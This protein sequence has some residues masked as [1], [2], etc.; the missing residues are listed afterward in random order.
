MKKLI[1]VFF[2]FISASAIAQP[3]TNSW[4]DYN[5]T[6]YKFSVGKTGLY[7]ISQPALNAVGLGNTPAEQFQLW[8]N[9]EEVGLYTTVTT[10]PL[11]SSDYLEFWGLMND[12]KKDA[13]LYRDPDYQLSDYYSLETDT[14]AYFLTVNPAGNN[15]RFV[16][17]PNNVTGNV[18]PPEPYFIN[19]RSVYFNNKINPGLGIPL[20][21][22]VYSSSYDIGEG[23]TSNDVAPSF[24]LSYLI[25]SIYMFTA[26]PLASVNFAV[27]GNA[28]NTRNVRVK[29]YNNVIDDESMSFFTY[30]K[31]RVDNIPASY[32]P[33]P[34]HVIISIEPVSSTSTDRIVVSTFSLTY[35]SKFNF[36]NKKS[37]YFELPAT[38]TGNYLLIDNFNFGNTKPVLLDITSGARYIADITSIPGKLQFVL[39][40]SS[41]TL[42]K[43]ELIS[44]DASNVNIIGSLTK[45]NFVN[46]GVAAN[47]GNYL[48][49]SNPVLYN[50]GSGVNNVDLYRAYRNS[51]NGGGYNAKVYDIDQLTDQFAYGIKTHPLAIKDFIQYAANTFSPAPQYVF[52][53]GK[54][55]AYSDYLSNQKSIYADQLNLVPT[56]G[57]PASD[58]LLSSPYAS[59][60]PSIPIGRLSVTSGNEIGNY[61][62]KV[63]EYEDAEASTNQ[64][65]DSKL[66]MKN[67]VHVIGGKDSSESDLFTFYMSQYKDIIADTLY[68]AK[69]E[70]FAKTTNTAV[71]LISGKRIEQLFNEGISILSYFGHS[72]ANTL[73]FNLSDPSTYHNQGRYPFFCVSGCTAGNNYI[74][75]STRITQNNLSISE[76]FVL[77]NEGGSIGFL[78]SSHL[79]VPPYLFHYDTS[80]YKQ[81]G[82]R[83]YGNTIGND[84]RSVITVLGGATNSL[85]F[86]TRINMEELNLHG[87]PALKINPQAKPDYV[88]EDPQVK[89]NPAFI[90]VAE[91]SFELYAKAYNIGKATSDSIFFEVK[92]T[93]PNGITEVIFRKRIAGIRYADSIQISVPIISSRDKGLNKITVTIDADNKVSELSENNNSITR[94]VYIYQDEATPS[95]PYDFAIVNVGN[96]K[97][98]A[99]TSDPLSP[100]QNY[101][102]E[103]DTTLLF[104]SS[105]KVSRTVNSPGG[106][107]EFDP[108]FSYKDSTVYYW[109][110]SIK[111]ASGLPSD[112]HWNN[113]SFIYLANSS[114]GSNQSHYYQHLYSD[115]QNIILDSARQWDYTSVTNVITDKAGVYPSAASLGS[116][117]AL[118]INGA[119]VVQSV[120]GVSGIIFTVL[121]PISLKP[122]LNVLGGPSGLYGSEA[123][124]GSGRLA[125]F[126]FNILSQAKRDSA[127][128]FLDMIPDNYIVIARNISGTDPASNTYAADWQADTATYGPNNSLYHRLLSQGFVLID[129]FYKPRAFIFMYQKNNPGFV[130][131]F[132]FSKDIYDKITLS[133]SFNNPDSLGYIISPKFGPATLWKE[134]HWRGTSLEPNSPDNPK[135]EIIGIDSLGNS[136]TLFNVDKTMQDVD[137][138]SVSASKYPFIQLKMRNEDSVKLTPYQLSYWRLNFNSAPEGALTPNL[139]FLSTDSLEQGDILHFGIAFKNISP[140]AFDSIKVRIEVID[141]NNV[142]HVLPLPRQKP[143]ISGDTIKLQYDIDTKPFPGPNTLHVDF[144]PDND[145]PEQYHFNN[146]LYRSFFVKPDKFNPLL[147]VTFDGI[148]ILNRD[149]VSARPHIVVKLKDESKFLSLNDTSLMKVQ[150]QFPDGSL[151]T[152]NFDNDT[153]RFI[154]ANLA[155]GENTATIDFS[156]SLAGDDDEYILIIS[157]KDVAGNIAGSLNY[158]IDFRVI[159]KP[160]I[161]NLLNYPNPFTTSTAF[162][163]TVT[164]TV[165]PQNIRI[166]ILT[167]TGKIIREITTDELGPL[168]IGRNITEFKWDGS[169]MYGQKVANGVYLYRVLTNLNGKSLDKFTDNGDNT[170]KYFTR[171]YGKMYFMR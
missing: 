9:G 22:Y 105:V 91:S 82:L 124:C 36:N 156:P 98:Y 150:I 44:E 137:I 131:N 114:V 165:V 141:N 108:G 122:W 168:H 24:P 64:T 59:L 68:G 93:Y 18:L 89:V 33:S 8:R 110:V 84:I 20:G 143:L 112:Y 62:Q 136:T 53:I 6:Y 58:I 102:M 86:L 57:N 142:T 161:S 72:S 19:T 100:A 74:Y 153:L 42:R 95:Y 85:D 54:G 34:D 107:I 170:D 132:V 104:N 160:M 171:G 111:P 12:G 159:S 14:S 30:L 65:L 16:N 28:L 66:W 94:E 52:L 166:Q 48:I 73:E 35:P 70:T 90:S 101:I 123:V 151:K 60:V 113:A 71:Q 15:L 130:P 152:Y 21:E 134:M 49:I 13:K 38:N 115:T 126:Q 88:I 46:Y 87:D 32:F 138:S 167:I 128:K 25:D 120:C 27:V 80:L 47:Q 92:R 61:L 121:D 79:G 31:K 158:Q 45:R 116:D 164:G 78:A 155:A 23:W 162:V 149:I 11:G 103:M 97:L 55:I 139:Y 133:H 129:S 69:V 145:Q 17:T 81:I 41:V 63:K 169:D 118:D 96:Q 4:I 67:V 51:S 154:P 76:K 163:F 135:V 39:P 2:V 3:Y 43:F 10:G 117:Y 99:S 26:G 109:R 144:N 146:F 56:F 119:L 7:R 29:L 106:V 157:G 125:N 147:D 83:N 5:K 148:H 1:I 77:A 140:T 75:D 40:P 50:N 127:V 37:F